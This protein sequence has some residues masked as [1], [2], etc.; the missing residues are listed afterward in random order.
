MLD[1]ADHARWMAQK[2]LYNYGEMH[3]AAKKT[4]IIHILIKARKANISL[5]TEIE[6]ED[7][8]MH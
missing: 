3:G 7:V 6:S 2:R 4:Y 5:A 1:L 8:D